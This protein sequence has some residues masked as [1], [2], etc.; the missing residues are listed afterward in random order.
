[1]LFGKESGSL[2]DGESNLLYIATLMSLTLELEA[3]E[4]LERRPMRSSSGNDRPGAHL[5]NGFAGRPSDTGVGLMQLVAVAHLARN[6]DDGI[7]TFEIQTLQ[8][9][10]TLLRV[11][12]PRLKKQGVQIKVRT[13]NEE[14]RTL[15]RDGGAHQIL[16]SRPAFIVS[17][18]P[19]SQITSEAGDTKL[20]LGA[21]ERALV[22]HFQSD[23]RR[24]LL[25]TRTADTEKPV[26]VHTIHASLG[27]LPSL[28]AR[29][30][31][32]KH[33]PPVRID[34]IRNYDDA[35]LAELFRLK[36]QF[37]E[38]FDFGA[39]KRDAQYNEYVAKRWESIRKMVRAQTSTANT[40][41]L[42]KEPLPAAVASQPMP[43]VSLPQAPVPAKKGGWFGNVL[44]KA[45]SWWSGGRAEASA[46]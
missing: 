26:N 35:T 19:S 3:P 39:T 12:A 5:L 7:V 14:I 31:Q 36:D 34:D 1:M 2:L 46:A 28:R 44:K 10:N 41:V 38:K 17:G 18:T 6:F 43:A 20:T 33:V 9:L 42:G 21:R 11:E 13:K 23:A 30:E 27:D 22:D 25:A 45:K 32:G 16:G 29:L 40:A 4:Q 37:K 8:E 24:S 15:L